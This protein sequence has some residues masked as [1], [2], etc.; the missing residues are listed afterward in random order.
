MVLGGE[1]QDNKFMDMQ[2]AAVLVYDRALS[3]EEQQQVDAYLNGKYL[4]GTGG[5]LSPT[6][7]DDTAS[8]DVGASVDIAVLDNDSDPDGTLDNTTVTIMTPPANGTLADDGN[9]LLTYTHDGTATTSDSFTYTVA[10]NLGAVSNIATVSLSIQD[11]GGNLPPTAVDDS[12]TVD[13]GASVDIP[14]LTND[15]DTDGT[16]DNTTVTIVTAPVNGTL[17]DDGNG[18]LTYTHDGTA[19]TTDSL[20]YTVA[21]DLGAVSNAATVSVSIG[22]QALVTNGLV[23]QLESGQGLI[24]SGSSVV[25][26]ADQ[27]TGHSSSHS[28][29]LQS[30]GDPQ[31][32]NATDLNNHPVVDFDG[33]DD[34]LE[35]TLTL[36]GLPTGNADRTVY[37]LAKYRGTG[38]G[39][40]AYGRGLCNR[41]FGTIVDNVGNLTAQ[42][43]CGSNDFSSMTAGTGAGW[44]VQS[45][46]L[47]AGVMNHYKDGVLLDT[48]NHTYNTTLSNMVLGG[49]LQDNNFMDMQVAAVLVYDR[50]LSAG[51]LQQ[52]DTYLND[53]YFLSTQP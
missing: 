34:K 18:L 5:N 53:K 44:L 32:V 13:V 35:R 2:V 24:V 29:D 36:F 47:E 22:T 20:T 43:W 23:L 21:D 40:F 39:G 28:N 14:V 7:S 4:Q 38:F 19:T 37:M 30:V 17:V 50:A 52:V 16:L 3:V 12:A 49:E 31:L 1:L 48:Q 42:G 8:A 41:A 25:S 9:G 33:V 46:V 15:S 27:S 11:A 51:E 10:D 6:T 45:I 26:W